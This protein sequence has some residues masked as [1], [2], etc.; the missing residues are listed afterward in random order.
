MVITAKSICLEDGTWSE[1]AAY[2]PGEL[3][4]PVRLYKPNEE[5]LDCGCLPLNV[6]YNPNIEQA[7]DFYCEADLGFGF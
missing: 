7:A 6:T 4:F 5:V 2:P 1:P 3:H